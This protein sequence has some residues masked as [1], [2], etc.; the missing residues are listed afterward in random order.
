MAATTSLVRKR[1]FT[2]RWPSAQ[3]QS[4]RHHKPPSPTRHAGH[5]PKNPAKAGLRNNTRRGRAGGQALEN[6]GQKRIMDR[7]G[8]AGGRL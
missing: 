4:S 7:H 6:R 2:G 1:D 8:R 5:Q 3:Q